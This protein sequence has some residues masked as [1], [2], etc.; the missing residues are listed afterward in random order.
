MEVLGRPRLRSANLL[1]TI[2]ICISALKWYIPT[3]FLWF[4]W[5]GIKCRFCFKKM[6]LVL[7]YIKC[8][9]CFRKRFCLFGLGCLFYS[10][11]TLFRSFNAELRHFY[12]SLY[13][14]RFLYLQIFQLKDQ[15]V[16][17]QT[18]QFSL[19]KLNGSKYCYVS[20]TI[21]LNISYLFTH[22]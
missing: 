10:V 3:Q 18:I 20:Q 21:Q 13:V 22:S 9:F 4:I 6:E 5:F 16:Q 7:I 12:K 15:T 19:S 11:S 17:F 1:T 8:Q 14:S 2:C